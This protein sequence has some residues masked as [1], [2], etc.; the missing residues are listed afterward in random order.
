MPA[1]S[2]FV[3]AFVCALTAVAPA[4]ASAGTL[5][6][7][8]TE[9]DTGRAV[10]GSEVKA[11]TFTAGISGQLDQVDMRLS[12]RGSPGDLTVEVRSTTVDG[13]PTA[14]VLVSAAV[15]EASVTDVSPG[16]IVSV[17]LVPTDVVAD[18]K[19]AIV[20][21]AASGDES[22]SYVAWDMSV[23]LYPRGDAFF[24]NDG[25]SNWARLGRPFQEFF[26]AED[27]LFATYVIPDEDGDGVPDANDNCGSV[28]NPDQADSDGDGIGDACDT[29]DA[30]PPEISYTLTP[31]SPGAG[32]WYNVPVTLDD[33]HRPGV[34]GHGDG[35]RRHHS[36]QRA[37]YDRLL[38]QRG[39]RRR[40][41][42]T[43]HGLARL[44]HSRADVHA[45]AQPGNRVRDR[46]ARAGR[47]PQRPH[48]P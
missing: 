46:S 22:N 11:Q 20:M 37:G 3:A 13:Q 38:V 35:V 32:G 47:G 30:T 23:N 17:P 42:R 16:S 6:Q 8:Q 40:L 33:G 34:F 48:R 43:G 45:L 31:A 10:R 26:F 4:S 41:D 29:T 2:F 9:F 39:Q 1:R 19:Y 36:E 12:R 27:F 18:Q 24:S 5:D 44:R 7:H 14:D 25:G 21:S 28:A 15:P